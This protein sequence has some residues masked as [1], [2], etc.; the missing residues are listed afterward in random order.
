VEGRQNTYP[1][2]MLRQ[3]PARLLVLLSAMLFTA[4]AAPSTPAP[5]VT[6]TMPP[7][8]R[9]AETYRVYAAVIPYCGDERPAYV[10]PET[11]VDLHDA[12]EYIREQRQEGQPELEQ[13][14]M[15]DFLQNTGSIRLDPGYDFGYPVEFMT[16]YHYQARI[17][18]AGGFD[19]YA[20]SE[21]Q[22]CG[23]TTLSQVGFNSER[24]QALVLISWYDAFWCYTDYV[25]LRLENGTWERAS[26]TT[27][28]VC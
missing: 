13:S 10:S 27:I 18:A 20:S 8:D 11:E 16:S 19:A 21:P 28:I 22:D 25:L 3:Q 4:C 9:E 15:D 26:A 7:F 14:T 23:Y 17:D 1:Y 24:N 12:S 6:P 5:T 2:S